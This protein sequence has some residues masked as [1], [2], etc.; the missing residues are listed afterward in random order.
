MKLRR[1]ILLTSVFLSCTIQAQDLTIHVN[2]KGKVG[3]VDNNGKEVIKCIYES[4]YPFSN[5]YAIVTQSKKMGII[6]QKGK[7]VLPIKY[8]SITPWSNELYLIKAGKTQGLAS[9]DG[10]IVLPTKYSFI[11]KANCY[12]KALIAVGGKQK[13][14]N[15]KT[16]M[17]G[18]K[19]GI[20]NA[21]GSV[22]VKPNYK[23]L[24]E[25]S[26]DGK[27][28][29]PYYEGKRLF[30]TSHY[31]ADTLQTDCSY[32]GFNKHGQSVYKSGIIDQDGKEI[33]KPGL[34]SFVMLPANG[35]ARYYDIK[36]KETVCGYHNLSTGKG[37]V[38]ATF[39]QNIGDIKFWSHGDFTGDIAPVNG[40]SWGF[41]DKTGKQVRIG[42]QQLK[43]SLTTGLWAAQ[44]SS[45]TWDVFDDF[46]QNI[47]ALSGF[48]DINLPQ[49][50]GDKEVFSVKKNALYGAV[51]RQGQTVI[52][53]EYQNII[54]NHYGF[55]GAKK[56][57]KWGALTPTGEVI[58]P[59]QYVDFI[60][61]EEF[62]ARDF[63]VKKEDKLY[64][65]YS[66]AN[67]SVSK[68]GYVAVS[69]FHK[70]VA[71]VRPVNMKLDNSEV[72]RAQVYAPNTSH[73]IIDTVDVAK[74]K[75]AFGYLLKSNDEILID[76]PISTLYITPVIEQLQ[77]LGFRQVSESE[78]K[79]ILLEVTKENRSYGLKSTLKEEEWNY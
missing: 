11:S 24:Y 61:P 59:I 10:K 44:T 34:Y 48:E 13:S 1:I 78:K 74:H 30:Y 60:L 71:Q 40:N 41:I 38:A 69:N 72:N 14:E 77:K 63:W 6:D 25:F 73:A 28:V 21:N 2:K 26:F 29:F 47:A 52:P 76:I 32:L 35:M 36:K 18:A 67:K 27:N 8:T 23:G 39:K 3:F 58:I 57:D 37:F 50:K 75:D 20:I 79:N 62:G 65:H 19:F 46:N 16:Y 9:H 7:A 45:G 15:K 51:N 5:G 55:M 68:T 22:A 66:I 49:I 17:L 56:N 12:G 64:Y 4:A 54:A 42:Y 70:D 53:F 31:L 33:L 43:H